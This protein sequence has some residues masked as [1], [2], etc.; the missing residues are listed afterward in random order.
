MRV[1]VRIADLETEADKIK[2]IRFEVFVSEQNVP[3]TIEMDEH[4]RFCMH[5]LAFD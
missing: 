5:L 4:D 3:E 2:Y 1:D